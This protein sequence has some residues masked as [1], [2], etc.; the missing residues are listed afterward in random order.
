MFAS[1]RRNFPGFYA[2]ATEKDSQL[3]DALGLAWGAVTTSAHAKREH[4]PEVI[5]GHFERASNAD[6]SLRN[7]D[8]YD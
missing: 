4:L 7:C 8:S 6:G 5:K 2:G 3:M 1:A